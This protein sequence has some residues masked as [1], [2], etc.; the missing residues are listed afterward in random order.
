MI[1]ASIRR[2]AFLRARLPDPREFP[3]KGLERPLSIVHIITRLERGG[4]TDCTLWQ[5]IGSARR[6][7]RV[8]VVSGP[9]VA[10]SPLLEAAR[11]QPRLRLA[12]I[13]SLKRQIALRSDVRAFLSIFLLLRQEGADVI[14]T[15]T[16]KAGALGRLAACLAGQ[17]RRVVHQP[18]GHLFYGYYGPL[19]GRLV[20]LAERLLAPLARVQIALSWR[21]VEEHLSRRVGSASGWRVVRSGIDLRPFR[22]VGLGRLAARARL[23]LP[24]RDFVVGCV[25][26][27]EEIKGVED[28]LR[29]FAL[30]ARPRPGLRLLLA[31]DGPLRDRLSALARS[32]G[33]EERVHIQAAWL[34]PRD[35]L[36]ALD[37]FVLASRNEGMGR[38]LVEAMA[39]GLPVIACAVGGVPDVLEEGRD[40]LLIPPGDPEAIALA[41]GRLADDARLC[42]RIARH[43]RRRAIAFGVGRMIRALLRIYGEVSE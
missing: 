16:S 13:P 15:H 43:A 7:H 26:R 18:H 14:H 27:L 39:A 23:G 37:L 30:A 19:G 5:A 28:L 6:G 20:T 21:G 10:P 12:E 29:G 41:I 9:S 3:R 38:A 42:S 32:S 34:D 22:R 8:L 17:R 36:P 11:H 2:H 4:S 31:G 25:C 24:A 33:L 40:G 1:A 35:V